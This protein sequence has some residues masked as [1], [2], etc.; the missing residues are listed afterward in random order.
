MNFQFN[1]AARFGWR[2]GDVIQVEMAS[3][4]GKIDE[5]G[6]WLEHIPSGWLLNIAMENC[7]FIDG[8]HFKNGDF[9]WLC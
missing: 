7:P 6:D 1:Q 5:N 2:L 4:C 3:E 8:L 9:P